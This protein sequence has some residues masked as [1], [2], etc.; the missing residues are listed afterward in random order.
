LAAAGHSTT[1]SARKSSAGGIV[2][3]SAFAVFKLTSSSNFD[4]RSTRKVAC[5]RTPQNASD[6]SRQLELR[7]ALVS[8]SSPSPPSPT[9]ATGATYP[10]TWRAATSAAR[11]FSGF[12]R[13]Y[14][15]TSPGVCEEA[16]TR[17]FALVAHLDR[18]TQ[19]GT[20]AGGLP[21]AA[22]RSVS[23]FTCADTRD[24]GRRPFRIVSVI[25]IARGVPPRRVRSATRGCRLRSSV[26]RFA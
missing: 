12:Q 20:A 19:V 23:S 1:R 11:S 4:G 7:E 6:E 10:K 3:P 24:A 9:C 16:V 13:E 2:I 14:R 25:T 5:G 22:K 15:V 17:C 21:N 8:S 18:G 26:I